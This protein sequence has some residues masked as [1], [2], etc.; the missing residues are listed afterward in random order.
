MSALRQTRELLGHH[1]A[2]AVGVAATA[3]LVAALALWRRA[4]EDNRIRWASIVWQ[5][6]EV[7]GHTFPHAAL[8]VE[9]QFQDWKFPALM[10]LDLGNEPTVLYRF[11]D[12]KFGFKARAL[13]LVSGT[14]A[15]R[16]FRNEGFRFL[17]NGDRAAPTA[18]PIHAG[19]LGSS[20]FRDRILL[21]DFAKQ[22]LAILGKGAPLPPALARAVEYLPVTQNRYGNSVSP[23]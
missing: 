11:S 22:R 17:G 13:H 16:N 1:R 4:P 18:G 9:A 19:S 14:V 10:Q 6:I 21:L 23:Q 8:M 3:A 12:P 2:M 5:S 7:D 20:F 15:N